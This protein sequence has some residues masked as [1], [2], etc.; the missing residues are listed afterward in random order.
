[1]LWE[2]EEEEVSSV[3]SDIANLSPSLCRS[4]TPS[5]IDLERPIP[6]NCW[7]RAPWNQTALSSRVLEPSQLTRSKFAPEPCI[8]ISPQ[9]VAQWARG[10]ER[11]WPDLSRPE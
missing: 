11:A 10:L 4:I 3:H 5:S 7:H 2:E 6:P 8:K 1:M 9:S